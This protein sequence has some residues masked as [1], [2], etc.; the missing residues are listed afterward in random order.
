MYAIRSYYGQEIER[1]AFF[2]QFSKIDTLYFGGGTPSVLSVS[3]FERI[4]AALTQKMNLSSL[5]EFTMEMNPDD[6][7][8]DY[9]DA[10]M[11]H[12]VNRVSMGIQSFEDK[13]LRL[14]NRRHSASQAIQAI[15]I[16]KQA[17]LQNV[18]ADLIYGFR[19]TSYNVCYTKLL[20]IRIN[21]VGIIRSKVSLKVQIDK[22]VE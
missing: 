4:L 3:D 7:R 1:S 20:R 19:I 14:M 18:S 17:G 11:S 6:I 5:Q 13:H 21:E 10:L 16:L 22:F 15:E 9:V 12:G 2:N 8:A